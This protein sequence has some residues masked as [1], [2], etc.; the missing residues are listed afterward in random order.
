MDDR[1]F[2]A[3]T[4]ALATPGPRRRLLGTAAALP[5]LGGVLASLSADEAAGK[6]HKKH[7]KRKKHKKKCRAEPA[8][9]TCAGK[10][11]SVTNNCQQAVNCGSCA[12][13]PACDECFTCQAA[14]GSPGVCVPKANGASCGSATCDNGTF[15]PPGKCDGSGGCETEAAASCAPYTT[16]DGNGC[17]TSCSSDDDCVASSYCNSSGKCVGD[18]PNGETCS[19]GG[20]CVSG[21]CVGDLCCDSAC[22]DA[23]M[24]CDVP[25]HEGACSPIPNGTSCGTGRECV[26]GGCFKIGNA[27]CNI[28]PASCGRICAGGVDGTGNYL[29]VNPA[30]AN[31]S[32]NANCPLGQ[33][34]SA[35]TVC[36]APC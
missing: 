5:L 27:A 29:C 18:Q 34:C 12:C 28:C 31:C 11:G 17:A 14:T 26:H 10:C 30:S 23:C 22:E 20:Q 3:L 8:S 1:H 15:T 13:S 9:Q 7:K 4:R 16:C 33:A 19:H 2:D 35:S 21:L 32:T 6:G 36:V 25:G 24:A